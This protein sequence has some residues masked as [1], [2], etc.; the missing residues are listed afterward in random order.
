[1]KSHTV[2]NCKRE[3]LR[4][5]AATDGMDITPAHTTSLNLD[6]HI[7]IAKWLRLELVLVELGPGL[8]S[9]HLEPG[10]GLGIWHVGDR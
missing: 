7:V 1:M 4:S 3:M 2:T 5:P 9:I 6:I 8:W 10:E